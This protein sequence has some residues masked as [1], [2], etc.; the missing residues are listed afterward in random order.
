[1]EI[2]RAPL[3]FVGMLILAM[4]ALVGLTWANY[5]FASE[6]P[7]GNDFIPRWIGTRLFLVNRQN[8][9]SEGTTN[10]IQRVVYGRL[11][12]LNED[13]QLFVYPFYSFIVFMPFAV[14][15]DFNL[16]RALWMTVLELTLFGMG[17][18]SIFLSKWRPATLVL[19]VLLLFLALWYHS[20]RPLVNGNASILCAFLITG[21]FWAIQEEHDTIAGLL[22]VLASIKP[23]MVV[24][25]VVFMMLWAASRH[26]WMLFWSFPAWLG[27]LVATTNLLLPGWLIDNLKQVVAY[28]SYTLPGSPGAIF[29]LYLPAFGSQL[30]WVLTVFMGGILLWEWR[31]ALGQDFRWFLW[32]AY[33]T[34]VITDLIGIRTA[35]A[36]YIALFP[37]LVLVLAIWAQRCGKIGR[38]MIVISIV[39]LFFGLWWLFL[40]TVHLGDQPIQHPI[41]FFPLPI[42]L[43]FGLYWVRGSAIQPS[44][45]LLDELR[46]T[47]ETGET[48]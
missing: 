8:P 31:A 28:P 7:G 32:A 16:A 46:S 21:V 35:T 1:L 24:L 10:E 4:L 33:L 47:Q 12:R 38:Y 39:F 20:V 27:L 2:R 42:F 26:R 19:I 40:A 9:Y 13:Q 23:Q 6:N 14:V 17:G 44:Y 29:A 25:L 11:A 36:N 18:L 45:P 22:L 3:I 43:L 41:M 30:G 34:L 5:R 48:V 37:A 15:K